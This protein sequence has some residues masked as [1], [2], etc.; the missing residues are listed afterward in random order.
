MNSKTT[1]LLD[2]FDIADLRFFLL[3]AKRHIKFILFA[4]VLVS[5]IVFFISLNIE[6]KYKSEATIVVEP[7][8]NKIVNIKE[9]YSTIN[10]G[11]RVNNLIAILESD[12][13][14]SHIVN[15]EKN[16]LEQYNVIT[17][18]AFSST[19]N[20]LDLTKNNLKKNGKYLLLR[21]GKKSWHL[22][23]AT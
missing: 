1:E 12:E 23:K 9:A 21:R 13:V 19:K 17:A 11:N 7:D 2:A 22:L 14:I 4:S 18:R 5:M 8:E 15:D 3:I 20:I 6:K 10:T 16:Q